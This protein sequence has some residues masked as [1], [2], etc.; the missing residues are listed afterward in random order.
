MGQGEEVAAG[1][2]LGEL[3]VRGDALPVAHGE[4]LSEAVAVAPEEGESPKDGAPVTVA[5]LEDDARREA[6]C[7]GEL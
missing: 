6:L 7:D 4:P 5:A 3:V 1:E 2:R